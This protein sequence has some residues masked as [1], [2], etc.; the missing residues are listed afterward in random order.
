[1]CNLNKK[2]TLYLKLLGKNILTFVYKV[3]LSLCFPDLENLV[4]CI[5]GFSHHLGDCVIHGI[6][7]SQSTAEIES[8]QHLANHCRSAGESGLT[9]LA[10]VEKGILLSVLYCHF[11]QGCVKMTI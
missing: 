11:N 5:T 7:T 6:A 9:L 4:E 8:G 2:L 1:L 10:A 3:L